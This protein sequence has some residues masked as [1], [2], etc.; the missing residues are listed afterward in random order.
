L[1]DACSRHDLSALEFRTDIPALQFTLR[2]GGLD[3]PRDHRPLSSFGRSSM[4]PDTRS[5]GRDPPFRRN[6][7]D[8]AVFRPGRIGMQIA[9]YDKRACIGHLERRTAP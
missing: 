2:Q 7:G 9:T 4:I 5:S 3:R 6:A 8:K 1:F